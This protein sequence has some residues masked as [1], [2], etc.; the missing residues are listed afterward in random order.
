MKWLTAWNTGAA[1]KPLA[2]TLVDYTGLI[3]SNAA[4][5]PAGTPPNSGAISIYVTD[6]TNVVIDING[7]Y[8]S[9][10]LSSNTALGGGALG[11]NVSG[12][13][14]TA[15]GYAA[16]SLNT[17]GSNNSA[18]G[19]NALAAV[20]GSNNFAIGYNA[21]NQVKGGS[22]NVLIAH[23]GTST[24]N[25]V[26]RIGTSGT[27]TTTYISGITGVGVSGSAVCVAASGQLGV[28][29]SSIR[30]KQDVQDMGDTTDTI[31]S[32]HPVQF[33]YKADGP[34]SPMQYGLI[35]EDV[36]K[37]A[38]DLI[39]RDAKGEILAVHYEKV[40]AMVLNQVQEQQRLIEK[41]NALIR[42]LESR[43]AELEH[44]DQ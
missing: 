24:D 2:A 11:A 27:Q 43:I 37:I 12:K 31:M 28:C 32:L 3:L 29:P 16:L 33:H 21:G 18:I 17:I 41:Q 6:P 4:V 8:Q 1:T 5:V 10:D 9:S 39:E 19:A 34:E 22:D 13:N 40:N 14:N 25:G 15:V 42:Q 30:F 38:P 36:A 7:Y 26:V 35:A 23:E 20:T 44:R